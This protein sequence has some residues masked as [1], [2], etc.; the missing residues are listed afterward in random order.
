M[1]SPEIRARK[2][3]IGPKYELVRSSNQTLNESPE[4][5]RERSNDLFKKLGQNED[6]K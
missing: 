3:R 1:N 2:L 5:L 4:K 6:D